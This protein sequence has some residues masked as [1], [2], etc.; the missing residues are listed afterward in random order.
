MFQVPPPNLTGVPSSTSPVQEKR[1]GS[2]HHK[3]GS[4]RWS[5]NAGSSTENRN[6]R[7][8]QRFVELLG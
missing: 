7:S 6:A 4:S 5:Y 1:F 8:F 2:N 3:R